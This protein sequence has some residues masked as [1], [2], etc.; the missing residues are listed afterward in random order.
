MSAGAISLKIGRKVYPVETYAEA[1]EMVLAALDKYHGRFSDLPRMDLL[2]SK[3]KRCGHVSTNGKVWL[4][5][6]EVQVWPPRGDLP[7]L[8]IVEHPPCARI[9]K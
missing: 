3:G 2:N 9:A 4:G 7:P 8:V 1:S 5:K 6:P